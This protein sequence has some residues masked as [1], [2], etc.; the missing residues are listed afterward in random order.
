MEKIKKHFKNLN[1]TQK[2]FYLILAIF[3]IIG[4]TILQEL[5][6]AYYNRGSIQFGIIVVSVLGI[7]LFGDKTEQN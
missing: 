2:V 5:G 7:F 4:G 1:N 3:I 6:V